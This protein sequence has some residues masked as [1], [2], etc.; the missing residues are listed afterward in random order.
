MIRKRSIVLK[1]THINGHETERINIAHCNLWLILAIIINKS[2]KRTHN[3][4]ELKEGDMGICGVVVLMF[5]WCGAAVNTI[6]ICGVAVLSN[7]MVCDVCVFQS[8]VFG[9]MKLFAVLWILVWLGDAVFINF[10]CGFAVFRAPP[11]SPPYDMRRRMKTSWIFFMPEV[12][13]EFFVPI[14]VF[15]SGNF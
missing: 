12:A 13:I 5:F 14:L 6:S 4:R 8:A 15:G 11:S 7:P 3:V 10:F 2:C 1:T 9:E